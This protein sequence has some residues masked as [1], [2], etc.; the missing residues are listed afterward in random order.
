[1]SK[2]VEKA[3]ELHDSG[4]NCAQAVVGAFV[5]TLMWMRRL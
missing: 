1:M 5:R 3:L 2:K 4:F